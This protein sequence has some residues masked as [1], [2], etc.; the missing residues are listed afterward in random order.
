MIAQ[1]PRTLP[2]WFLPGVSFVLLA[3]TALVAIARAPVFDVL[4]GVVIV[5][6][7]VG[8]L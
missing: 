5:A 2:R 8:A 6:G 1:R 4:A 7:I 3:M